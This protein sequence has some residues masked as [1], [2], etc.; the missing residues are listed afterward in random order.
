MGKLSDFF[1][2]TSFLEKAFLL[3]LTA[4]LSGLLIPLITSEVAHRN[5]K[6]QKQLEAELARQAS[7]IESQV[8]LLE[9]LADLMWEYQ[10]LAIDVSYYRF[11]KDENLYRAAAQKYD[12]R[13]AKLLSHIR[14]EISKSLRLASPQMYERLKELYNK[15]MLG[16]DL[17]LRNLM[18]GHKN[19]WSAFNQYA[20]WELSERVDNVLNDLAADLELKAPA[21]KSEKSQGGE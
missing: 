18:E 10:L 5:M 20:V 4:G 19:D 15:E 11:A 2:S 6:E 17:R 13:S 12:N 1:K 7:V 9:T 14:A 21:K 16:L 3:L 8:Q